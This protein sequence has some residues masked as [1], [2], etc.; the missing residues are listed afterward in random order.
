MSVPVSGDVRMARARAARLL[1]RYGK[2]LTGPLLAGLGA[3]GL[4]AKNLLELADRLPVTRRSRNSPIGADPVVPPALA[5]LLEHHQQTR[6]EG[7][8]GR[9]AARDADAVAPQTVRLGRA[10]AALIA[11]GNGMARWLRAQPHVARML[12]RLDKAGAQFNI[13]LERVVDELNDLSEEALGQTSW[14][15]YAARKHTAD[16]VKRLVTAATPPVNIAPARVER[17]ERSVR[18]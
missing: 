12:S 15:T 13:G 6:P 3:A 17:S 16:T 2:H 18:G 7:C 4:A 11:Q 1:H 5:L 14:Q 9:E 10:Y 8:L